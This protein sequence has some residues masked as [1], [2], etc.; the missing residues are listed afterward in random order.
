MVLNISPVPR[1]GGDRVSAEA[2][3][4]GDA[5][6]GSVG[7]RARKPAADGSDE[8][9]PIASQKVIDVSLDAVVDLQRRRVLVLDELGQGRYRRIVERN[10]GRHLD[11]EHVNDPAADLHTA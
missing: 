11:P 6:A 7:A 5:A 2:Y 1:D 4:T 8:N 9:L 10:G 3:E